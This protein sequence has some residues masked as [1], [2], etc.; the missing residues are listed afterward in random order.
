MKEICQGC[1]ALFRDKTAKRKVRLNISVDASIDGVEM[2]VDGRRIKQILYNLI[3]NGI[4][5]NKPGGTV[6]VTVEKLMEDPNQLQCRLWWK[7]PVSGSTRM[8]L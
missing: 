6:S 2:I 7:I 4:K 3:D 8:I 5:Y 1:A